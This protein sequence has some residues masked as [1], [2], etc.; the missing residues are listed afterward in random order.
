[1]A[2]CAYCETETELYAGASPICVPC[3][4]L[5]PEK[6]A[7]RAKLVHELH[8]ATMRADA[9]TAAFTEV[10]GDI[11]SRLPHPDGVQR[12]H[13]A[14]RE[15]DT[16]RKAMMTANARLNDFLERGVV[17]EDLKERR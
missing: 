12:I 14:S 10:T 7:V 8:E 9:A 6:R 1:M 5:S 3:A 16:A 15:M 17:P 13:N 4:D 11:P 2:R